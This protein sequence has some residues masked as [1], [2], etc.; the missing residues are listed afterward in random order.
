MEWLKHLV[1][2]KCETGVLVNNKKQ[3]YHYIRYTN[4]SISYIDHYHNGTIHDTQFSYYPNVALVHMHNYHCGKEHGFQLAWD[5][6]G[7]VL[8]ADTYLYGI[9]QN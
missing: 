1:V 7:N 5:M 6:R 3:G 8:Y 4:G 2:S 9:K